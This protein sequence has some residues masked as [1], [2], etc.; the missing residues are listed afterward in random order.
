MGP[1]RPM[2]LFHTLATA[3]TSHQE[4]LKA[5]ARFFRLLMEGIFVP[6]VLLPF[7]KK[8]ISK[9]VAHFRT[10]DYTVQGFLG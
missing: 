9:L 8:W 7:D 6:Y 4:Y 1:I 5:H 3:S 2:W 10:P